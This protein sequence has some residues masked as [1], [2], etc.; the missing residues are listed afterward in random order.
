MMKGWGLVG[1]VTLGGKS[2]RA[3]PGMVVAVV[4]ACALT[5]TTLFV[6]GAAASSTSLVANGSFESPSVTTA[7]TMT[8]TQLPSWD[9]GASRLKLVP[10][11]VWAAEQGSQSIEL[12]G[13]G[14]PSALSQT[15]A[16]AANHVYT[17]TF[18]YGAN[19]NAGQGSCGRPAIEVLWNDTRVGNT[20]GYTAIPPKKGGTVGWTGAT[21]QVAATATSSK[22]G[23]RSL[24]GT[25]C[26]AGMAVD[27]VS[28]VDSQGTPSLDG[29][30]MM[31]VTPTA[32]ASSTTTSFLFHYGADP[33][34]SPNPKLSNGSLTIDV[35]NGWTA[36]QT[37]Q[38]NGPGYVKLT[39]APGGTLISATG[40]GTGGGK[41]TITSLSLDLNTE[42]VEFT[43]NGTAPST[44]GPYSF[45]TKEQ[46]NNGG[47][48]TALSTS[49]VVTVA[50]PADGQ[51][52][53]TVDPSTV[54]V[55]ST[56]KNLVFTYTA[57]S[58]PL[59]GGA[60]SLKVPATWS[61]PDHYGLRRGR[62]VERRD[63]RSRPV[64]VHD[65]RHRP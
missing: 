24:D 65:H 22:L 11:S 21:I 37:A 58:T 59:A 56:G 53:M 63:R 27:D 2:L 44:S 61:C 5:L 48:L 31:T 32:V 64:D 1:R 8:G 15:L 12:F 43:Y 26:T 14:G 23:F 13:T 55:G 36:P 20:A 3:R 39:K 18:W 47:T 10:G 16:T 30:G 4:A 49:P 19:P 50:A 38:S 17:I 42:S 33:N 57:G 46:S 7:T 34:A 52:T 40:T 62:D 29:A 60:V 41:I 45:A 6:I 54:D 28:V 9:I 51:G 35:P 25:A